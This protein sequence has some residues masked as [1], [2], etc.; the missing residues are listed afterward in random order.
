MTWGTRKARIAAALATPL[1]LAA[2]PIGGVAGLTLNWSASVPPGLYWTLDRAPQKGEL[3]K[4]C[5]PDREPFRTARQRGYI[6]GGNCPGNYEPMLKRFLAAKGDR[7]EIGHEGVAVNGRALPNSAP[8]PRDGKGRVLP[9]ISLDRVLGT[10]EALV[11]TDYP[12]SFDGR[13]A[14]PIERTNLVSAV[15]P[16]LTW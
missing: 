6:T 2:V 7:I 5:P 16:V 12:D 8:R 9:R 10:R 15:R 14:G 3:V 4:V 11:M 1:L 13:Y